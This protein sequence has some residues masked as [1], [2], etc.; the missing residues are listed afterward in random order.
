MK[1]RERWR[2][3]APSLTMAEFDR[4]F[5][6]SDPSRHMLINAMNLAHREKLS[7]VIHV[8][9]TSRPQVVDAAGPYRML[10]AAM[11]EKI[12]C[13]AV[14]C[15]SFNMAGEPIVYGPAEAFLSAR[16]MHLDGLAGEGWIHCLPPKDPNESLDVSPLPGESVRRLRS[17]PV[18][19]RSS[20]FNRF[21]GAK[22]TASFTSACASASTSRSIAR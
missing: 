18:V 6:N 1:G 14:I 5:R 13:E 7:G 3:L 22:N 17:G 16:A 9:G 8:D 10:L 2:P 12:G 19:P 15:T 20:R 4:S 11:G 21:A